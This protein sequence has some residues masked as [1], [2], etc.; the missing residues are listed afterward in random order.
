MSNQLRIRVAKNPN[1]DAALSMRQIRSTRRLLR[2]VFG[3][4]KPRQKMAILLPG[5]DTTAVEVAVRETDGDIAALA[6][7]L[8]LMN[9]GDV[10]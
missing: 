9:G 4:A 2:S 7:A 6:E 5:A 10:E 1:P 3:T 8:G